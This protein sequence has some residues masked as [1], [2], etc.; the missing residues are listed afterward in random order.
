VPAK[1]RILVSLLYERALMVEILKKV[2]MIEVVRE[3]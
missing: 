1:T 2:Q 3:A